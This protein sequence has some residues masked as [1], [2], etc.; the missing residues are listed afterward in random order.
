MSQMLNPG[1]RQAGNDHRVGGAVFV[2]AAQRQFEMRESLLYLIELVGDA[3]K[4]CMKQ[5]GL[6]GMSM[7]FSLNVLESARA[8]KPRVEVTPT[9]EVQ[10]SLD[11]GGP[12]QRIVAFALLEPLA[13]LGNHLQSLINVAPRLVSKTQDVAHHALTPQRRLWP[14]CE[15]RRRRFPASRS[16]IAKGARHGDLH[17]DRTTQLVDPAGVVMGLRL[18]TLEQLL[19]AVDL[20]FVILIPGVERERKGVLDTDDRVAIDASLGKGV[21]PAQDRLM[22]S[23]A[24]DQSPHTVCDPMCRPLPLLSPDHVIHSFFN[25]A[26]GVQPLCSPHEALPGLRWRCSA[27][28]FAE[29]F[30]DQMMKTYPLPGSIQ[31]NQKKVARPQPQ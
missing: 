31:R 19:Q 3:R 25:M 13:R 23:A 12:G 4:E 14:A 11:V 21:H 16:V 1:L 26:V 28:G 17:F 18:E 7:E 8:R 9:F 30:A 22:V 24:K 2:H 6:S 10:H 5:A 29:E 27:I 20:R 15:P